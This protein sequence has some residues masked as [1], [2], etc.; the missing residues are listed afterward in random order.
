MNAREARAYRERWRK[1]NEIERQEA[2][3]ATIQERWRQLNAIKER[4][5]RLEITRKG[6]DS[7]AKIFSLWAKLRIAHAPD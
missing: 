4:A 3:T 2:Q 6:D 5:A 1:V 7:E